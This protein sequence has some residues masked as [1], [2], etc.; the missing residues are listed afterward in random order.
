MSWLRQLQFSL[1][2]FNTSLILITFVLSRLFTA[3]RRL[4]WKRNA[5]GTVRLCIKID[6]EGM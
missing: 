1:P 4:W 6:A 2:N 3:G 5:E